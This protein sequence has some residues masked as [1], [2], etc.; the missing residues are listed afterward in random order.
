MV[1]QMVRRALSASY[2]ELVEESPDVE[3]RMMEAERQLI[4]LDMRAGAAERRA[5]ITRGDDEQRQSN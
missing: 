4:D 2:R 1:M 3:R 5:G